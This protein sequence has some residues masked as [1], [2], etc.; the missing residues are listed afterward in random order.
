LRTSQHTVPD[1]NIIIAT[2]DLEKT[3]GRGDASVEALRGVTLNVRRGEY[4]SIMGPSGSGK[5]TLLHVLGCLH[6][7]TGG[8]YALDGI[9]VQGLTDNQLSE[10]R[11]R[12]LGFVFQKF[13]LLANEDIVHNVALPLVYAGVD[14]AKRTRLATEVLQRLGLGHRLTHLPTELSG[15]EDQRV[16]IARALVN[17]PA[18][19]FADEPTGNL[20]SETGAQI[21][22]VFDELNSEG[23]TIV[24]VTHD[25]NMAEYASRVVHIQDGKIFKE[26]TVEHRRGRSAQGL[27]GPGGVDAPGAIDGAEGGRP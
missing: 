15:G 18:V 8:R 9:E 6:Q 17:R 3:Y 10:V 27:G 16:A 21:M 5:S 20:D 19:I 12:K 7:P 22:A 14:M 25:R 11:S 4:I 26:E 13:N 1:N 23:S 24:Q 2:Q